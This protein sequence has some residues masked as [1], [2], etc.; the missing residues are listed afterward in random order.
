MPHAL[1]RIAWN[2]RRVRRRA[3]L[4]FGTSFQ[5]VVILTLAAGA[6]KP[7]QAL[8][9]QQQLA[10]D[11]YKK[12]VEINAVTETGDTGRAADAMAAR[13]QAAGFD[14]TDVQLS[15]PA[16]RAVARRPRLRWQLR[17]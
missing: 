15:K 2:R 11:I 16:P 5:A 1:T 13:L 6:Y 8:T 9:P 10:Y 17:S 12:L 7:A 3:M 4:R 14:S